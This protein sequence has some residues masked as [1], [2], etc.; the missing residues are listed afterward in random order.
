MPKGLNWTE[1]QDYLKER[2]ILPEV[3]EGGINHQ[4]REE[5]PS[6]YRVVKKAE[7]IY[8]GILFDSAKEMEYFKELQLLQKAGELTFFLR[9]VPFDLPGN[10]K[11]RVDFLEFYPDGRVRFV[12]VKGMETQSFIMK[13]KQVEALYPVRIETV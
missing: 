3:S 9:Q 13:K 6:K 8:N 4:E 11:Y 2:G 12:D 7:R 10:V 5:K 1:H